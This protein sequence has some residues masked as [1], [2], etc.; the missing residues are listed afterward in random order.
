MKKGTKKSVNMSQV[1][2]DYATANPTLG[3][4]Q[5]AKDLEAQ[6]H[7]AYPALVSQALRG[8]KSKGSKKPAKRGRKPG[9]TKKVVAAELNLEQL[10]AS[11]EFIRLHGSVEGAIDS[12]KTYQKVSSLFG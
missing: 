10:K 8:T 4:T 9:A 6:G 3:P 11:A 7:K 5:I 12:L 1:I 2:R